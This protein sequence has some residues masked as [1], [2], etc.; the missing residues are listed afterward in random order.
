HPLGPLARAGNHAVATLLGSPAV[1]RTPPGTSPPA[2]PIFGGPGNNG[3]VSLYHYGDLSSRADFSSTPGFPRLTDYDGGTSQADAATYTGAPLS[4]RLKFK[5][6]IKIDRDFF[7][8]NFRN[9]GTRKGYSEFGTRL[10]IPTTYFRP[11]A[12]LTVAPPGGSGG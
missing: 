6:E 4:P 10:K 5:Y 11:V 7:A 1:Q 12:T 3:T 2:V 8:K 9:T